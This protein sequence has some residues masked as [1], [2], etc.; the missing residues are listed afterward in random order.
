MRP[1][2]TLLAAV[3][4]GGCGGSDPPP[5]GP[6]SYQVLHY[7]YAF[8]L[9]SRAAGASL[10]L[11]V[12]AGG[13]DCIDIPLRAGDLADIFLDGEQV[14]GT[15]RDGVLHVCGAGWEEGTEIELRA[16]V[17][18][19][20]ETWANG[21]ETSQVGYSVTPDLE[22]N[23]FRY[24]VSWVGGCDRFGPCDNAP[25]RFATYRFTVAHPAGTRVLCPGAITQGTTETVCAFDHAGGPTYSTFGL[26]AGD[27]W[28]VNDLGDWGGVH[29]TF[30]D[31]PSSG[32]FAQFER[33]RHAG[34]LFWMES[35][36]GPYPYGDELRFVTGPTHWSGFEHPGNIVLNDR[37]GIG[38]SAYTDAVGH[39]TDHEIVHMWAGDQSTLA[40]THDFVWK[41]AMAEYLTFVFETE[42]VSASEGRATAL[43]WKR[44]ARNA[45]WWPVPGEQPPLLDYYGDVY[46]PGPMILFRQLEVLFSREAVLAALQDLWGAPRAFGVADVQAALE[47]ATGA[48]LDGYFDAWVYGEGEPDWPTFTVAVDGVSPGPVDVTVTPTAGSEPFGCAFTVVLTGDAAE[49]HAVR[50]DRGIDGGG[51][52]VVNTTPGFAVTGHT[53]DPEGECLATEVPAAA[54]A[55]PPAPAPG[56]RRA[57]P[58]HLRNP[59]LAADPR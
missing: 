52:T 8:D 48:D 20:E 26:A 41:E 1:A 54:A 16:S 32:V 24:L 7:D 17:V 25:D 38:I 45:A 39:V 34:F 51:A 10:T 4:L 30:H 31:T 13:G 37:L 15:L 28:T 42:R 44:F 43:A 21:I 19:A 29:A 27:S 59:W 33:D 49:T 35:L 58:A 57:L 36:F 56:S 2:L 55:S 40:T 6:I 23:P 50:I 12:G 47:V 18:V 11:L 53:F 14:G 22:G 9:E 46:G 5:T 3:C